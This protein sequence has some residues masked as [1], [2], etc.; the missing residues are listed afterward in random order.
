MAIE[1]SIAEQKLFLMQDGE[2]VNKYIISTAANGVG[3]EEGSYCTPVGRFEIREKIG[4]GEDPRTI[5]QA[6]KPVGVWNGSPCGHDLVLT[7]IIRLHGLDL[8]NANTIERYIYIHGTNQEELLGQPAS[9]GC[10]RMSNADV[11]DLF[12]RVN[13]GEKVV[14]TK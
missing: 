6:R 12:G 10:I 9:C 14:V 3:F 1:I 4:E 13:V 11:I 2:I 7:R 8:E 5:F